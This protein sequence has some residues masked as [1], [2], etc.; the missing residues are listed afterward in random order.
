MK[1]NSL[2]LFISFFLFIVL[3]SCSNPEGG[4]E[5]AVLEGPIESDTTVVEEIVLETDIL[6][7]VENKHLSHNDIRFLDLITSG[8]SARGHVSSVEVGESSYAI[9]QVL[10]NDN[11][12]EITQAI[13]DYFQNSSDDVSPDMKSE[14]SNGSARG[15]DYWC[16]YRFWDTGCDCFEYVYYYCC[17]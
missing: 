15:C 4:H 6:P 8:S 16:Y 17:L 2:F 14:V 12:K 3:H 1:K 10:T 13:S 9:G 11:A 5:E 7:F